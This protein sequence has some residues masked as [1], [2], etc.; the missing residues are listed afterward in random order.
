VLNIFQPAVT[1]QNA[2]WRTK[3][4]A[5]R[6]LWIVLT[7][8]LVLI[9]G[10][11]IR[12]GG[13]DELTSV[14]GW[15]TAAGEITA[16]YG[17]FL[18]LLQLIFMARVPWLDQLFGVDQITQSHRWLG[19]SAIALIT[20]HVVLTT[21]GWAL[22]AGN[23]LIDETVNLFNFYP[24][25]WW[26]G[27]GFGLL[28]I[29]GLTS[30]RRVKARLSYEVWSIIHLYVYLAIVL[31]FL[32]QLFVGVDFVNDPIA[33][34]YWFGLY[35]LTFGLL[36]VFRFGQPALIS[37]RHRLTVGRVITETP[38]VVSLYLIGENMEQLSVLAGQWFRLRF[39]T[40]RGWYHAHPFS[41]SS[42][43]NGHYLRFTIKDLGDYTRKLQA[44]KMG[45]RVFIEG[46]YGHLTEKLQLKDRALLIAGGVG[47][48]PLRALT[49]TLAV[50]PGKVTLLY[51]A[52][53]ADE[54]I[55][56][57]ELDQ[58]ASQKGYHV[59]YLIGARGSP[60]M[61]NDPFSALAL[62]KLVPNL[63]R[64][65]IYLC[66]PDGMMDQVIR[67]L[68]QLRIP[69]KQIHYEKFSF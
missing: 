15:L 17:T 5:A 24:Y 61:P 28:I 13:L 46:P 37:R 62:L 64:H 58:L 49:E 19:F 16:L 8:N 53:S 4:W 26:A 55:F 69:S 12:H 38:G 34:L 1:K 27:L 47:I 63:A 29:L 43:P 60:Q 21:L 36:I 56:K 2:L 22:A 66:G 68:H 57:K 14:A 6:D 39:L 51:R 50:S 45:T 9:L 10:M 3:L 40:W 20:A 41:L 48:T 52:K 32:H 30:M 33:R 25:I 42:V 11:W 54:I 7:G 31:A 65:D 67:T 44:I 23:S 18:V 59:H 35:G